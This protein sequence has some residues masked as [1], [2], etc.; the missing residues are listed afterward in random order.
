MMSNGASNPYQLIPK[1]RTRTTCSPPPSNLDYV[2]D[3]N[4]GKAYLESYRKFILD[5]ESEVLLP[6]IFY[7]D[8]TAT[9]QFAN[10]PIT[11]LKFTFGIFNQDARGQP[12]MW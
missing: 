2:G 7:I 9:G 3:I 11:P 10:L 4:T 1:Y 5:P 8:G 12:H 6:L